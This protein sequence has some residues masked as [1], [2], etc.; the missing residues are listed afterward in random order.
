MHVSLASDESVLQVA[1]WE[2][3]FRD[4]NKNDVIL[5]TEKWFGKFGQTLQICNTA[6]SVFYDNIPS[7]KN[8]LVENKIDICL[9]TPSVYFEL[10]PLDLIKVCFTALRGSQGDQYVVLV[11]QDSPYQTV[12]DLK[13]AKIS[14]SSLGE[15]K[16]SIQWLCSYLSVP[17]LNDFFSKTQY[18]LKPYNIVLPV[19]FKQV[20]ACLVSTFEYEL[21]KELNPQL[22]NNTRVL[23]TSP[24]IISLLLAFSNSYDRQK[25]DTVLNNF[26]TLSSDPEME[27]LITLHRFERLKRIGL[28]NLEAT[29]KIYEDY[30]QLTNKT[31]EN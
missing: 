15:Y 10:E 31:T 25:Y 11:H 3:V 9:I 8:D 18:E 22:G 24:I 29:R 27:Q 16:M 7:V 14:L 17:S 5:T 28:E 1:L 6:Q 12:K 13:N 26:H 30:L 20:D 19:Y 21:M 4:Y 23:K 2:E